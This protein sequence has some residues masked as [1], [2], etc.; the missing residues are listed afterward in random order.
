MNGPDHYREA[1]TY[2]RSAAQAGEDL[3]LASYAAQVAQAH[4]TLALAAATAAGYFIT[5]D[6][7][8]NAWGEVI[9]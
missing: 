2:L 4:A 9:R 5:N 1:E 6:E 3:A 7:G 8:A